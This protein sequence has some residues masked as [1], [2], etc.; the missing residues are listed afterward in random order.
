[1]RHAALLA[2]ASLAGAFGAVG[3]LATVNLGEVPGLSQTTQRAINKSA[4]N[5]IKEASNKMRAMLGGGVGTSGGRQR[6]AA[7]GWTNRHAVRVA[8]KRRNQAR[9]KAAGRGG[10]R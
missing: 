2:A 3:S 9:H 4:Q 6:R 8:R 5:P 7:Y 1:M 10:R